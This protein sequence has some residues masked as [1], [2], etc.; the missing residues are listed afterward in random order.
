MVIP[1]EKFITGSCLYT[2]I[3]C[4]VL[5]C[6]RILLYLLLKHSNMFSS[7]TLQDEPTS[8]D[9]QTSQRSITPDMMESE[10][11]IGNENQVVHDEKRALIHSD[12]ENKHL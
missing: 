7:L 6:W 12:D 2:Y 8:S 4:V 9:K 5:Y 11:E 3:L 10:P 1:V